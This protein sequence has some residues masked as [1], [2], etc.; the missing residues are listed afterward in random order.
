MKAAPQVTH[1][2]DVDAL[3]LRL[4]SGTVDHTVE[5]DSAIYMDVDDAGQPLGIEFLHSEDLAPYVHRH[6]AELGI[7]ESVLNRGDWAIR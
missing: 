1:D 2:C 5:I 4:R 3:Y 7:P 6:G